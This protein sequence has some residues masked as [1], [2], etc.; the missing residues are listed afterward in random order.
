MSDNIIRADTEFLSVLQDVLGAQDKT[1][2]LHEP[3]FQGSEWHYVKECIDSGW[4]SSV[5]KYVDEFEAR[6]SEFTGASHVVAVANG[7]VALQVA[8][9]LA[10]VEIGDE[11]LVP[12]L[13]FVATANAVCH[14]GAV[15]HF[16]D[17]EVSTLGLDPDVLEEYLAQIVEIRGGRPINRY[18][19]RRLAAVIPMHVFGHAMRIDRLLEVAGKYRITVVEDAAESLGTSFGG[20]HTGTFG[21]L[22]TLSFNG[23]KIITTGGGGAIMTNDPILGKR[24]KHL[25]TTAKQPHP[26]RFFHDEVA[27]NF[28]MPNLNAALGCAQLECLPRFVEQK[29]C[30]AARYRSAFKT[31]QGISFVDEPSGSKSNFWLNAV[32]INSGGTVIRD[33]LLE[34]ANQSGYQCRP[35]WDL[36]HTLPMFSNNPSANLSV[37]E[38]LAAS[39]INLPSSAKLGKE[40]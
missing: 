26:W 12:T 9:R 27:Y 37:S 36:M 13:T 2:G 38:E 16:A 3:D 35:A 25:T 14:V 20:Q 30:L 7:T 21:L 15:P 4:V 11:V 6:L 32:R 18:T 28:R 23:N 40:K 22:G 39:L 17:A 1:M 29:R 8:L 31:T 5:G 19:G 10:G 24:A 33:S 34:I